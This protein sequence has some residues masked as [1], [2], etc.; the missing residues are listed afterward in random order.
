M[1]HGFDTS[2][3][4][5]AEVACHPEHQGARARLDELRKAGEHFALTPQVLAEF[6]HVVTD[7]RRFT[8][9]LAMEAALDRTRAWWNSPEIDR[10]APNAE[11]VRVFIEWMSR[12]QLGRK[13][14]LDTLLA[15]TYHNAGIA[16]VLTTNARDFAAF[17]CFYCIGPFES[18]L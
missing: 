10:I 14:V 7:A 18:S 17:G 1:A 16:R 11:D 8:K 6:I 4:V 2:F 12:H 9:P 5:A 15:A 13:R 3:L